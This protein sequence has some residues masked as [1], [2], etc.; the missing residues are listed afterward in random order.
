ML[1][2]FTKRRDRIW[3]AEWPY[4]K[5]ERDKEKDK[6]EWLE[7]SWTSSQMFVKGYANKVVSIA[8]QT[9]LDYK[10]NKVNSV[11]LTK[12]IF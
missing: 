4:G 9:L 12:D 5:H 2:P 10:K 7:W 11:P 6:L 8:L 1:Q 3:K